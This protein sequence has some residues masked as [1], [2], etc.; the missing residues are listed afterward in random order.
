MSAQAT[1][2]FYSQLVAMNAGIVPPSDRPAG[3]PVTNAGI[4]G[5]VTVNVDSGGENTAREVIRAINREIRRGTGRL[6]N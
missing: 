4:V 6:Y 2:R 1:R 5:D 3:G